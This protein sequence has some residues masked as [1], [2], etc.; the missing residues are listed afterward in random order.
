MDIDHLLEEFAC[1]RTID[2]GSYD[3]MTHQDV[4]DLTVML[5]RRVHPEEIKRLR[6]IWER[7]LRIMD[8]P[9]GETR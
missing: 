8:Q 4:Q 1:S 2:V 5:G 6:R 7:C 9:S 3:E